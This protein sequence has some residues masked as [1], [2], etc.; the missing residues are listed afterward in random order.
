M[1]EEDV[2]LGGEEC[3]NEGVLAP[4]IPDVQDQ[5]VQEPD[6]GLLHLDCGPQPAGIAGNIVGKYDTSHTCFTCR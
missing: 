2:C 1:G 3:V 6:I 4:T 5:V